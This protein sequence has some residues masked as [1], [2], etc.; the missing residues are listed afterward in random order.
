LL[1]KQQLDF[2][3]HQVSL[4]KEPWYSALRETM[5]HQFG[6]LKY[7]FRPWQLVECG[8]YSVPNNGCSDETNDAQAAYTQ[9][10]LWALT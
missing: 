7:E 5:D 3:S 8:S 9:A 2:L 4:E 1:N 10:L 6:S